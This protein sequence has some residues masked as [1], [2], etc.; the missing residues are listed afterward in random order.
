MRSLVLLS[1]A[2]AAAVSAAPVTY[3]LASLPATA[4]PGQKLV[5]CAA[6]VGTGTLDVTLEF[7]NVST[8]T[9]ISEQTVKLP[10]LGSAPAGPSPCI[11]TMPGV[12]ASGGSAEPAGSA[13][14]GNQFVAGAPTAAD[15]QALV[16]GVALVRRPLLSFR[17][18]QVTA[19]IQVL[20]PDA[21]GGMR[22]VETIPLT[23]TTH[24]GQAAP[25]YTP[26]AADGGGHH[27]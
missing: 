3:R 6:N 11:S 1:F 21:S 13:G 12:A 9:V 26:A 19:S 20:A 14:L 25:V 8:G 18:A 17:E 27:K 24:P 22:T 7:L 4:A 10:A 5:L 2:L 16:V 23:R 15:G